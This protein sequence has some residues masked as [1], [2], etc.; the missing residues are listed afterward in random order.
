MHEDQGTTEPHSKGS[1]HQES[2]EGND[3][4]Q[5]TNLERQTY[6]EMMEDDTKDMG[7]GDLDLDE[8]EKVIQDPE[9]GIIPSQQVVLL[10]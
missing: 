6:M 1:K 3:A 4:S 9:N 7:L 2:D 5:M 10:K 8:L